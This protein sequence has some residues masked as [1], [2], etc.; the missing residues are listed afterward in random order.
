MSQHTS[1]TNPP[2]VETYTQPLVEVERRCERS[3][4]ENTMRRFMYL[5]AT[6]KSRYTNKMH[7]L[8][9]KRRKELCK[10]NL[11]DSFMQDYNLALQGASFQDFA[12]T[13]K[14]FTLN[15]GDELVDLMEDITFFVWQ[16]LRSRS[17]ADYTMAA[18]SFLKARNKGALLVSSVRARAQE[19]IETV[20]S[21]KLNEDTNEEKSK[22]VIQHP[23]KT[24][25]IR[26]VDK[27][28]APFDLPDL[29]SDSDNDE[30][31]S[32]SMQENDNL[33]DDI[34]EPIADTRDLIDRWPRLKK[35]AIWRKVR[36]V[37][38]YITSLSL[39]ERKDNQ[40]HLIIKIEAEQYSHIAL[41][42]VDMTY[43]ILD[44]IVFLAERGYQCC[45]T[46]SLDAI[47]HSG[48]SY[49]KWYLQ[50]NELITKAKYLKNPTVHKINIHEYIK[51]VN[52]H[53]KQGIHIYKYAAEL[54]RT[55]KNI[56]AK[57]LSRL[58]VI[59]AD[60]INRVSAQTTRRAP[61][62]LCIAGHSSVAKT[63]F[64][65]MLHVAYSNLR[66]KDPSSASKYPRNVAEEF[67]NGYTSDKHTIIFDDIAFEQPAMMKELSPSLKEILNIVNNTPYTF[68][69]AV[70][71]EKGST[72][73]LAELLCATT[74]SPELHS[75]H[76]FA[77]PL[78]LLRRFAYYIHIRPKE[79]YLRDNSVMINPALLP[80]IREGTFPDYWEYEIYTTTAVMVN[81][82]NPAKK[83][84]LPAK[85]VKVHDFS[86][87]SPFLKWFKTVVEEHNA[88]QD[89]VLVGTMAMQSVK[90]CDDCAQTQEQ[91]ECKA[92]SRIYNYLE[93]HGDP[94]EIKV[95]QNICESC[96]NYGVQC[97]CC[98]HCNTY[99]CSCCMDCSSVPCI[100][101]DTCPE[102][103]RSVCACKLKMQGAEIFIKIVKNSILNY[104]V[105]LFSYNFFIILFCTMRY[106]FCR[107]ILW[108]I[109]QYSA[110][111][112]D[113]AIFKV[114]DSIEKSAL[115]LKRLGERVARWIGTLPILVLISTALAYYTLYKY[116]TYGQV[117][118]P[119]Y[120]DEDEK[121]LYQKDPAYRTHIANI[122]KSHDK[123]GLRDRIDGVP[124]ITPQ[125]GVISN[126]VRPEA[127]TPEKES[128]WI[129][130]NIPLTPFETSRHT[131]SLKGKSQQEVEQILFKNV[132]TL[133]WDVTKEDGKHLMNS[134]A[135]CLGGQLYLCC[136]HTT[137]SKSNSVTIISSEESSVTSNV[138]TTVA[139]TDIRRFSKHD[140]CIVKIRNIPNKK[141]IVNLFAS[142]HIKCY[143]GDAMYVGR[144]EKGH[145]YQ[146]KVKAVTFTEHYNS[147]L[148]ITQEMFMGMPAEY[149][150][151]GIC[152]CP[153][154]AHTRLGP[155]ILGIHQLG[156]RT[157]TGPKR[158]GAILVTR[159]FLETVLINE[160]IVEP[161]VPL[162]DTPT[163]SNCIKGD[164]D[165]RSPVNFLNDGQMSV[166]YGL[167]GF[168]ASPKSK[169]SRTMLASA[170][171][172]RGYNLTVAPP[173]FH[174]WKPWYRSLN[175]MSKAD[176]TMDDIVLTICKQHM[177]ERWLT[178]DDYW[179]NK[180][181]IYD[182][183]SVV[184]GAP[185]VK[186]VDKINRDTS[187]GSPWRKT[188]RA[189]LTV[190]PPSG[191]VQIPV[192]FDEEIMERVNARLISY[193]EGLQTHP[194]FTASLKDKALPF[195]KIKIH[196]IRVFLG[197]PV[198]FTI[199]MRK[200]LLSFI[201]L[202]QM[203]PLIFESA[204]GL[205]AHGIAWEHLYH[206]LISNGKT[207]M[208]FGDYRDY[209][210]TMRAHV[211]LFA[212]EAIVDFHRAMGCSEE[213]CRMI[214]ALSYDIA[215]A[216]VDYNGTLITLFGKNPSGQALTVIINGIV[217][218]LY[219]RYCYV[220]LNPI[221]SSLRC[222]PVLEI[223]SGIEETSYQIAFD[224]NPLA[225]F[226]EVIKLITYG[227]DHGIGVKKG[228]EWFNHT[229]MRDI[230][231]K[232]GITYTMA[233]KT[234][235]SVPYIHVDECDFL[236]RRFRFDE[237]IGH[238]VAPLEIDSIIQALMIGNSKSLSDEERAI[239]CI[240]QQL[241]EFFLHGKEVF[242]YWRKMLLEIILEL[243]ME[244]YAQ[245]FPVPTWDQLLER[246]YASN[247]STMNMQGADVQICSRCTQDDC[248]L[249][250]YEDESRICRICD[251]CR[252]EDIDMDCF[253][254]DLNDHC[255]MCGLE[256][257]IMKD[258]NLSVVALMC[259]NNNCIMCTLS[260]QGANSVC[261]QSQITVSSLDRQLNSSSNDF[262]TAN[263]VSA[264]G[265]SSISLFKDVS[266]RQ[267]ANR[268]DRMSLPHSVK[269]LAQNTSTG[270]QSSQLTDETR[271]DSL[272]NTD[273][274]ANG[275]QQV[276]TTF[277]D[278]TT[279]D[280]YSLPENAVSV[281]LADKLD[282]GQLNASFFERPVLIKT[283]SWDQ[284]GFT[285]AAW[286]P[287]TLYLNN[288]FI[289][290][291]LNNYA[292]LRGNL[293]LKFLINSSP[294][295][296]G[297]MAAVYTPM[298]TFANLIAEGPTGLGLIPYS[299]R[300]HTWI[301]PQENAGSEM[302]LP[303]IYHFNYV[304]I[305][306]ATDV[307][308]LG[309]I[310]MIE[311][312]M[313]ASANGATVDGCTIQ[314]Y[315]WME[316]PE[317]LAPTV[318]LAMQGNDEYGN[319][320][321]SA[322][323]SAVAHWSQ[324]LEKVP[325]IG[326]FAR[327]TTIG[328][329]AVSQIATLF[330][331]SN[332]PVISNVEPVK[333]VPFHDLASAH[334][335]E[336]TSKFSL[337]P[338]SELSVD[339]SI[340]GLPAQDEL[341]IP[342]IVSK[343]SYLCGKSW[344][345]S[346][347]IGTLLF[348][349][350]VT[351]NM[352]ASS[353]VDGSGTYNCVPTPM[354]YIS[355]MFKHWRGDITFRFKIIATKYHKGRV[356]F[357]WDP[358]GD[359]T[360]TSDYSHLAFTKIIDL[361][362]EDEIIVT[363][364][365][366]QAY[367]W[368]EN[369]DSLSAVYSTITAQTNDLGFSNGVVTLRVLTKLSAPVDVAPVTVLTFVSGNK[370]LEFANPVDL[371]GQ[372][373]MLGMQ[374]EDKS[375]PHDERYL[376]NW[377]EAIP[378]LRLLLRRST[379]YD[380][381]LPHY[382]E[383]ATSK[384]ELCIVNQGRIP[385]YPGYDT[386]AYTTAKGVVTPATTYKY[387]YVRPTPLA[388][389]MA[390]FLIHRGSVRWH[391]NHDNPGGALLSLGVTRA[392][393][394]SLTANS[395]YMEGVTSVVITST[396]GTYSTSKRLVRSVATYFGA[397]GLAYNNQNTQTG[398]SVEMPMMTNRKFYYCNA[399]TALVGNTYDGS[400]SDSYQISMLTH[401]TASTST[402]GAVQRFVSAGTDFNLHFF[403]N[404]PTLYYNS[405]AGGT[406]V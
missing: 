6:R 71:E 253:Y 304:N 107:F 221:K 308:T 388:H 191:D 357:T 28:V 245:T 318:K 305:T 21:L 167:Q 26:F 32:L 260:L 4:Y 364:P 296:Y 255:E 333:N 274:A 136:N 299:Q 170:L 72:P 140:L 88:I 137:P 84:H 181:A 316:S 293:H 330:G 368:L 396:P 70:C 395:Q 74:N 401:P 310:Q 175:E 392:P 365:Y 33:Y 23:G 345:Y 230:L 169:V 372:Y 220:K 362:I 194:I 45:V 29:L 215:F 122:K 263:G 383:S 22:D 120:L 303:F 116:V 196:K 47:F 55:S 188:K 294:F 112:V 229:S 174:K 99:P 145:K 34:P 36:L 236:K 2:C 3:S 226:N 251:H 110:R 56:V 197:S 359:I 62:A 101:D 382:A 115:Y 205:D 391:Y 381:I 311:Y 217:N 360:G 339:P 160:I 133:K 376:V 273:H 58:Q 173:I 283:M 254:C 355:L 335:S 124:Y 142:Q 386:Y 390:M 46:G 38:L 176:T 171:I 370:N 106:A 161:S 193:S 63:C 50:A 186:F 393:R 128:A 280:V 267:R 208:V 363:V 113:A 12:D 272:E 1:I 179:K 334:L 346:D 172:K 404:A 224:T 185:G 213:H 309:S 132:V 15:K 154:L 54:D 31:V 259:M 239:T 86:S 302:V 354:H 48:G 149:T 134:M 222:E 73:C 66:G 98:V 329:S 180:L 241:H 159:E 144:T 151:N 25:P 109:D 324:Y 60:D 5:H 27:E 158:S 53:I 139:D 211:I 249:I 65:D 192:E 336:P 389:V 307:A 195:D 61:L 225:L 131:L 165:D 96:G 198:D 405:S 206:Y 166:H 148:E 189:Y 356:R 235:E 57:T 332:V 348:S 300:P 314:V 341:S 258:E 403:L 288:T 306:S 301:Y 325:V 242:T 108:I 182:D 150:Y 51:S 238:V 82:H 204:P 278:T 102:C 118:S 68:D 202:V 227:D 143:I 95:H 218:C 340:V 246:Y 275:D 130:P 285:L 183:F 178:V 264:H 266:H 244:I 200:L 257:F 312:A 377:G 349:A 13:M 76:Y 237:D 292:F 232:H 163:T 277:A 233:E 331:W 18:L 78:A 399:Q 168:R 126:E 8:A 327:A 298:P 43:A 375:V 111:T 203:N 69:M 17:W 119:D 16:L 90:L 385:G 201:R 37:I 104:L 286:D 44:L 123:Y 240:N 87:L 379:F 291:K 152:G 247:E 350:R 252:F 162:L 77:C 289:K 20:R 75:T 270:V 156:N 358:V 281:N 92:S 380:A 352:F 79:Q 228:F 337:D 210:I 212:F 402:F 14:Q 209:D 323:A 271:V 219:V 406:P 19:F 394:L 248:I 97:K 269:R 93:Y 315:A 11:S 295:Y 256:L 268:C 67:W 378:S 30:P 319:G 125:G 7:T 276:T 216:L 223:K 85:F 42:Q 234:R 155:M 279:P 367:P 400:N 138:T 103:C 190:L 347:A 366:M 91:C 313:L 89:Q 326:R 387:S 231:A 290:Y 398:I 24:K 35:S 373:T 342:Y 40:E 59:K 317:L 9:H 10:Q 184:N 100:C 52:D 153:L 320:P 343:E 199:V 371:N 187:A 207:R 129:K 135:V 141:K 80:T 146:N 94:E 214:T 127:E 39:W 338:K 105:L 265:P 384:A 164:V 177:V 117:Y 397:S 344:A 262:V 351:P 81:N 243:D 250:I 322:P 321:V 353:G 49:E 83:Y 121:K 369:S 282:M 147:V 157:P 297:A 64:T 328:A 374:G 261:P 361:S 284:G 114:K 287:W 41:Y